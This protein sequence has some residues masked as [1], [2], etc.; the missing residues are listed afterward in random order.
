MRGFKKR[1]HG[2]EPSDVGEGVHGDGE[3][4]RMESESECLALVRATQPG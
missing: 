2:L 4:K 1:V 3:I